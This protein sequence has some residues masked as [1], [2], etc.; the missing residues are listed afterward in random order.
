MGLI[1]FMKDVGRRREVRDIPQARSAQASGGPPSADAPKAA[2]LVR[3]DE[4][5]GLPVEHL[6]VQVD[7][8]RVMLTGTTDDQETREKFVLLVENILGVGQVDDQLQVVQPAP[9]ARLYSLERTDT[10][11]KVAHAYYGTPINTRGSSRRTGC[12]LEI[13]TSFTRGRRCVC[14]DKPRG[15]PRNHLSKRRVS[16]TWRMT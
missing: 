10:L 13:P 8:E 14:P 3:L 2:A 6:G 1:Q 11:S 12:C 16:P 7:G 9:E 15:V 4:E 5:M